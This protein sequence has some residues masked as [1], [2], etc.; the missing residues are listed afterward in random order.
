M[1]ARE[2][3]KT[4]RPPTDSAAKR[5]QELTPASFSQ[6]GNASGKNEQCHHDLRR[7]DANIY[8]PCLILLIA[9]AAGG[10]EPARPRRI[11]YLLCVWPSALPAMRGLSRAEPFA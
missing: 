2:T 7:P 6:P 1:C 5:R 9:A 3:G 8:P 4:P 10:A 11:A